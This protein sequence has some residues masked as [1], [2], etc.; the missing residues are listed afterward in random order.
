M[1]AVVLTSEPAV[2]RTTADHL[3]GAAHGGASK[4]KSSGSRPCAGSR[5]PTQNGPTSSHVGRGDSRRACTGRSPCAPDATT[6]RTNADEPGRAETE[7]G[8]DAT[9]STS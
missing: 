9:H 2:T 5:P 7:E 6:T 1:G 8:V 4:V 3:P